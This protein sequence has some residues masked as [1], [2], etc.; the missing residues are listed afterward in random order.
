MLA[1][2]I[3]SRPWVWKLALIAA[4]VF[5]VLLLLARARRAGEKVGEMKIKLENA[6][7]VAIARKKMEAIPRPSRGDVERSLR[8][9]EF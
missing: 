8:D 7:A 1:N 2:A 3:L 6:H 5:S 4:V 9:G